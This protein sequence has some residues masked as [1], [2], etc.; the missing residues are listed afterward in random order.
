MPA[1]PSRGISQGVIDPCGY[2]C[3]DATLKIAVSSLRCTLI[4]LGA[5]RLYWGCCVTPLQVT[6]EARLRSALGDTSVKVKSECLY[7]RCLNQLEHDAVRIAILVRRVAEQ[8]DAMEREH[9][10]DDRDAGLDAFEADLRKE[11]ADG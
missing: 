1:N 9:F 10:H 7:R 4:T 3:F 2:F 6:H 11:G 8:A 5:D